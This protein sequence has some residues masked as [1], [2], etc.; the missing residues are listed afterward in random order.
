MYFPRFLVGA[1]TTML[2]VAGWVYHATGSI[3]RTTGW[4]V[5][6]A[7]ILQLGYFVAVAGL[8]YFGAFKGAGTG[9]TSTSDES[10]S[11]PIGR[12]GISL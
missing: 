9:D 12:D 4:T 6:I 10:G 8:I 1:T 2:V 7:I 11:L 3:W 5:L